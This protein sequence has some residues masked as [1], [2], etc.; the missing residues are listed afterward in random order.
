MASI[1][2]QL[3]VILI[4]AAVVGCSIIVAGGSVKTTK[5]EIDWGKI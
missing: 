4:V 2:C 5:K 1:R 3:L